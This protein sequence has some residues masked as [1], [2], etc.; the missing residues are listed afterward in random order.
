MCKVQARVRVL[1]DGLQN[2]EE[3]WRCTNNSLVKASLEEDLL[4]IWELALLSQHTTD[5]VE[6]K[7]IVHVRSQHLHQSHQIT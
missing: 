6:S 3:L 5:A 7:G 4:R 2:L 1:R